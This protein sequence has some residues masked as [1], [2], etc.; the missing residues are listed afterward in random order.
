MDSGLLVGLSMVRAHLCH[1]LT[2]LC[3]SIH[4]LQSL[5]G[6]TQNLSILDST[7]GDS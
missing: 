5:Y 3:D 1:S 6:E 4:E 7:S 2:D